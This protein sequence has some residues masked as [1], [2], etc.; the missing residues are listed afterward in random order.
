MTTLLKPSAPAISALL[1]IAGIM[2]LCGCDGQERASAPAPAAQP[3]TQAVALAPGLYRTIQTGD[4]EDENSRCF[5]AA[6]IAKGSFVGSDGI[7]EGWRVTVDRMSGGKITVEGHGPADGR[8]TIAGHHDAKRYAVDSVLVF[9]A[10]GETQ[11][12]AVAQRGTFV[13]PDCAAVE[14][15]AEGANME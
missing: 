13:S 4:V 6:Q 12:V 3:P 7:G 14:E 1:A 9:T 10:A 8:M 2:S 11:R 15:A 5:T